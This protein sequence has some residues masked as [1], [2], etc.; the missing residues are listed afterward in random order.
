M[1]PSVV[2]PHFAVM[3]GGRGVGVGDIA[4]LH[5]GVDDPVVGTLQ[6]LQHAAAQEGQGIGEYW[7]ASGGP[8]EHIDA[9]QA[10][11]ARRKPFEEMA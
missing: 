3:H 2:V 1:A 6:A 5:F 9:G 4:L 11:G 8:I 10:I 7:A